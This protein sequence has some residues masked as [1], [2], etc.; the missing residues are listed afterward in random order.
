MR[1]P[2]LRSSSW[3]AAFAAALFFVVVVFI[4]KQK[5]VPSLVFSLIAFLIYVPVS[6]WTDRFMYRR[7][8]R[9]QAQ[10]KAKGE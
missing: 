3:R 10:K 4:F 2:T 5:L 9:K 7:H 8:L 6:Y 1:E